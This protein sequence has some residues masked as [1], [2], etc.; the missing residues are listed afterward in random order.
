MKNAR[1]TKIQEISANMATLVQRS[2]EI[3]TQEL[4]VEEVQIVATDV[5]KKGQR[6]KGEDLEVTKTRA[7]NARRTSGRD[8]PGQRAQEGVQKQKGEELAGRGKKT[9]EGQPQGGVSR[10]RG[11]G[12]VQA[13]VSGDT[14]VKEVSRDRGKR[15]R[16]ASRLGRVPSDS[17]R[18]REGEVPSDNEKGTEWLNREEQ[19]SG[20]RV[21]MG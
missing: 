10:D 12:G 19:E 16:G 1:A 15:K 17:E 6:R 18:Q 13:G 3:E 20:L 4:V 14:G 8:A 5:G 7:V 9:R 21:H 2:V 11:Q